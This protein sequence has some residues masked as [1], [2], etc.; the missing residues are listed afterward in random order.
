M[1]TTQH[2]TQRANRQKIQIFGV[3]HLWSYYNS[4]VFILKIHPGGVKMRSRE[5]SPSGVIQNLIYLHTK[6]TISPFLHFLQFFLIRNDQSGPFNGASLPKGAPYILFE[7]SDFRPVGREKWNLL[8][9]TFKM[10]PQTSPNSLSFT[11]INFL[12]LSEIVGQSH[13]KSH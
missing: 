8:L 4:G 10:S 7:R 3:D 6:S 13:C 12:R 2:R 1:A 11:H 9:K 5:I